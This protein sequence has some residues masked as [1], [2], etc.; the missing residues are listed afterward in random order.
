MRAITSMANPHCLEDFIGA[1][2][3]AATPLVACPAAEDDVIG[4]DSHN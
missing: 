4:L 2:P 3:L 1:V